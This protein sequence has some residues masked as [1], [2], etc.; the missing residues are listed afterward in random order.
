MCA[1]LHNYCSCIGELFGEQVGSKAGEA[2]GCV[3]HKVANE[4]EQ[5]AVAIAEALQEG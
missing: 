4:K 5:L 2:T 3:I 1:P